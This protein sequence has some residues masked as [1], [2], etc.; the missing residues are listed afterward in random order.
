MLAALSRRRSKRR[1]C[2]KDSMSRDKLRN[3]PKAA[4]RLSSAAWP[5]RGTAPRRRGPRKANWSVWRATPMVLLRDA[6]ALSLD[7]EPSSVTMEH[8]E[9]AGRLKIAIAQ[10][11]ARRLLKINVREHVIHPSL[12]QVWLPHFAAWARQKPKWALPPP[13]A[14]IAQAKLSSAAARAAGPSN[15][16]ASQ[17]ES[18]QEAARALADELHLQDQN[19][20]AWSSNKDIAGRVAVEA[21]K[22]SIEGPR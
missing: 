7:F 6:V 12:T 14:G 16:Y 4:K 22:H 2:S 21:V 3:K 17:A 15:R 10:F 20:G 9:F 5:E 13:L 11:R 19:A 18:W 8:V 1:L